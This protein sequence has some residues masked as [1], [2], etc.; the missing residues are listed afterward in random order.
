MKL[1]FTKY[2]L[3]DNPIGG[4]AVWDIGDR[5]YICQVTGIYRSESGFT[6]LKTRHL[7]GDEAP[8]V[9]AAVVDMLERT[10]PD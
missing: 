4:H 5:H 8:D 10:Y 9:C 6:M 7:C 1:R 3:K 2:G